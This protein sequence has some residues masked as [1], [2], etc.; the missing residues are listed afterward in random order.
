MDPD[1]TVVGLC[2]QG[3]RAEADGR[4]DDARALFEQAWHATADD[5]EACVAAHYLARHQPTPEET[6][7][8]NQVCLDR[9]ERVGDERV[10]GFYSSLHANLARA[11][12]ELGRTAAA[13][14]HFE[15]AAGHLGAVPAG[16]YRDWMR[17]GIAQ[18]LRDTGAVKQDGAG[19]RLEALLHAFCTRHDLRSLC[20]LL[21]AYL[22][23]LGTAGDRERL[24]IALRMLHAEKRL[25]DGEQ[26]ALAELVGGHDRAR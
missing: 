2:T 22:G 12:R 18:G 16:Q 3:M 11:N 19:A 1:N 9:A 5:Y 21:P 10:A 26:R 14:R 15:L 8:W 24:A 7:H 13:R 23:D 17:Y 25:P 4:D 20:L 6:L